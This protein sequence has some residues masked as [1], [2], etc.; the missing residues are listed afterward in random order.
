M[1][2]LPKRTRIRPPIASRSKQADNR[3][4][5]R[6]EGRGDLRIGD[7]QHEGARPPTT[8]T[9][10]PRRGRQAATQRNARA[11]RHAHP[12]QPPPSRTIPKQGSKQG[13]READT[14]RD[15]KP[16]RN[17][18]PRGTELQATSRPRREG[19]PEQQA[20]Q[21]Y[22]KRNGAK[23][24]TEARP[25]REPP[26]GRDERSKQQGDDRSEGQRDTAGRGTRRDK[27][28]EGETQNRARGGKPTTGRSKEPHR[29]DDTATRYRRGE[30][31]RASKGDETT[32]PDG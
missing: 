31:G 6:Y 12:R 28:R 18:Q 15:D 11:T 2:A 9:L 4:A 22:D 27:Q 20:A 32:E 13:R 24:R 19:T 30:D 7:K 10:S 8:P 23:G 21:S 14:G 5:P 17:E 26:R 29:W 16:S 1:P 3:P 25:T